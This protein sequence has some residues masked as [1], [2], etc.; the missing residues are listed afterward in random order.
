MLAVAWFQLDSG[1]VPSG[2][3]MTSSNK[4]T[5]LI[6]SNGNCTVSSTSSEHR[7]VLANVAFSKGVH[8]WEV[9]VDRRENNT[10]VVVGIATSGVGREMMLGKSPGDSPVPPSS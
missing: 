10:D 8:Y 7:V 5:D 3:N 9:S 1:V 2:S 4:A 6:F